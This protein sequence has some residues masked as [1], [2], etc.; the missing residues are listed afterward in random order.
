MW[1]GI[2]CAASPPLGDE[3]AARP[4]VV[5]LHG[6]A[7]RAAS[8]DR[9]A[10]VLSEA[11]YHVCNVGYPS[12]EHAIADLAAQVVAPAVAACAPNPVVPVNFVTHSMGGII[13]RELAR[14]ASVQ[15]LGRVVMLG[16]PNQGSEVVD[17]LGGWAL[18]AAINGP[19][20]G[21]LGTSETSV[22]NLLGK[23][24]FEVGVIAGN[25]SINWINSLMIPGV[26]DGK[27]SVSNTKLEGMQ[28]FI[29]VHTSHPFLMKDRDVIEHTLHF[30][31]TGCFAHEEAPLTDLL[32]CNPDVLPSLQSDAAP[33]SKQQR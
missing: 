30:L 27:V 29:V 25:R 13:V 22:P 28:D 21:E 31:S 11:G 10:Q 3:D 6:L 2:G 16:P 8:M 23:A 14:A 20:G 24:T 7:R 17:A 18:F 5:L 26:D 32:P 12:R 19:A 4:T 1:S 9:M 33:V 15:T